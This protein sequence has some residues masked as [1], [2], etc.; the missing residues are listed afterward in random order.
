MLYGSLDVG[1]VRKLII[2][3]IKYMY[4][5]FHVEQYPDQCLEYGF[6]GAQIRFPFL[7][8]MIFMVIRVFNLHIN[9]SHNEV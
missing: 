3:Q 1:M 8:C 4:L 9:I 7:H 6:G 2:F 5:D